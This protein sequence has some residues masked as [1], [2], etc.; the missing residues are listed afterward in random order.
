MKTPGNGEYGVS[1]G[2][3]LL[4]GEASSGG[5]EVHSVESL[6]KR[7]HVIPQITQAVAKTMCSTPQTKSRAP[8]PRIT[9]HHPLNIEK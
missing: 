3:L 8:L 4:P 5:T 9:L 6:A 7:S 2:H 1:I